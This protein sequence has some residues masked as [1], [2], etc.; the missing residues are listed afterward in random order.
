MTHAPA[1]LLCG[2]RLSHCVQEFITAHLPIDA[3]PAQENV[4]NETT[5][6]G[7]VAA[8]SGAKQG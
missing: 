6:T 7:F 1:F 3:A 8:G 2:E 5:A 4:P